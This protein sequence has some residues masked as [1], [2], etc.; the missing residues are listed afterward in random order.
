VL[1]ARATQFEGDRIE[2]DR[3]AWGGDAEARRRALSVL[4]IAAAGR[5]REPGAGEVGRLEARLTQPGFHGATLGGAVIAVSGQ[6][7]T[8]ARDPGA[9]TGRAGG[10]RPVPPLDLPFGETAV[11][12][13]RLELRALAPGLRVEA[14]AEGPVLE[15]GGRRFVLGQ[16]G[17]A[18]E[19]RW[20][21]EDHARHLLERSV[22][23]AQA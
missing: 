19:S 9:L 16:A 23:P 11:W 3:R 14:G 4:I 6:R 13:G 8:I 20:L 22:S 21:L 18:A 2:I 12:D 10:G 1:I 7:L 17:H 5:E 15:Q